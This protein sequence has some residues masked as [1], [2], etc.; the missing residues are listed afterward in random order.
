MQKIF[1][2]IEIL[3]ECYE[4]YNDSPDYGRSTVARISRQ[5]QKTRQGKAVNF[6]RDLQYDS[7][8][9]EK[10]HTNEGVNE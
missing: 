6:M 7:Q 4:T 2:Q 9:K 10:N 3:D 1:L 8:L 5:K